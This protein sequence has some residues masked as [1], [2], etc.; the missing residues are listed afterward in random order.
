MVPTT[1]SY[2]PCHGVILLILC[3][4]LCGCTGGGSD[5][6]NSSDADG[7]QTTIG[8]MPKL[9]GIDF[10][11]AV[12]KGALEA[13]EELGVTVVYDGPV[14]ADVTKQAAM[15]DSWI[16]RKFDAITIA[17][18]DPDAISP[19]LKKAQTRGI[20]IITFD[21]DA[22]PEAR[23]YFVNQCT[24]AAVAK[25][26]VEVMVGGIGK[27]GKYI[28]LT[29]SLTAAN[30]NFW[31]EE[32]EKYTKANYPKMVNLS[33]QPK[34]SQEDQALATQVTI[35]ILK[36][37]PDVQ[38]IYG[39]TSVALPGAAEAIKKENAVGRVFVTGL[40][41]PNTMRA[42][43]KDG[44]VKKFI[45]WNPVDQGYL[46]VHVCKAYLEGKITDATTSLMAGRLG[47]KQI[48]GREVLLGDPLVF[49]AGNID[50]FDF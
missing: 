26:L 2:N 42:F 5:S 9:V 49:D 50:D 25:S 31:M 4:L 19:V 39:M 12:E 24:Y 29:G 23:S 32:M 30:Q 7:D 20:P 16:A 33:S 14:D 46:A 28:Y 48:R 11:N 37:Y 36:S 10:F 27:E 38:G 8:V 3:A 22:R 1:D 13:G 35:D 21:A 43:V 34:P 47:E 18:N 40:S 17:P 45:L 41:T 6:D 15:V 44:T